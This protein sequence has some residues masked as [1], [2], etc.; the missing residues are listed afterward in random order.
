MVD[1]KSKD[2]R[3]ILWNLATGR[4][5]D[6][7]DHRVAVDFS[8]DGRTLVTGA[9]G[10]MIRLWDWE[11]GDILVPAVK[12]PSGSSRNVW[13]SQDSKRF[14]S[15]TRDGLVD[16]WELPSFSLDREHVA[17]LLELLSGNTI[18][19][20]GGLAILERPTFREDPQRYLKAWK[21]WRSH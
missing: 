20:A 19:A 14:H 4:K 1:Y 17:P 15:A 16:Q 9:S 10:G 2:T 11:N 7:F 12:A 8:P 5:R 13:F 18:D 3:T 6:S 21:A